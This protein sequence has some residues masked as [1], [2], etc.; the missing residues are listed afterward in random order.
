MTSSRPSARL[1]ARRRIALAAAIAVCAVGP[2]TS[3]TKLDDVT[4]P[5]CVYTLSPTTATVGGSSG[6]ATAT[7]TTASTCAWTATTD[8]SWAA[9]TKVSTAAG[10][11][12][13]TYIFTPNVGSTV[14]FA[15]LSIANQ[16]LT[17]IQTGLSSG[18]SFTVTPT[19]APFGFSGGE[20]VVTVTAINGCG[21]TAASGASWITITSDPAGSGSGRVTYNVSSNPD[22]TSR[23]AALI[24]ANQT[25][26][27]T[28]AGR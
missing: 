11:G 24:V 22:R 17:L 20:G 12:T 9:I 15:T 27:V 10:N 26:T 18:C 21:W 28:Q 6:T 23:T 13:V 2:L 19:S 25:V 5:N 3:C 4:A 1:S 8:S 7:V 16:T 14:R